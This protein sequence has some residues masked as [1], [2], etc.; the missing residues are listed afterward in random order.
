LKLSFEY[1]VNLLSPLQSIPLII[2]PIMGGGIQT[3]LG[4]G[5]LLTVASFYLYWNVRWMQSHM[6]SCTVQA[7]SA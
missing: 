4:K 6:L 5:S 3:H 1:K 7:V 2:S